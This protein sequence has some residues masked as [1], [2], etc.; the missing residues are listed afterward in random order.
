MCCKW[1]CPPTPVVSVRQVGSHYIFIF[2][3]TY[4]GSSNLSWIIQLANGTLAFDPRTVYLVASKRIITFQNVLTRLVVLT[5]SISWLT[6][7]CRAPGVSCV[8]LC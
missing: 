1:V 5:L 6:T 3:Q 4:F 2:Q 8:G 7:L